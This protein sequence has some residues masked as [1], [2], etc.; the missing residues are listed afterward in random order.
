[1]DPGASSRFHGITADMLAAQ[2]DDGSP[3]DECMRALGD[4]WVVGWN[5]LQYDNGVMQEEGKRYGTIYQDGLI[6][7]ACCLDLGI[8]YKACK[9]WD[10]EKW[11]GASRMF[12]NETPL[13][14]QSRISEY[15]TFG[16]N[17]NLAQAVLSME[18]EVEGVTMHRALADCQMI[19]KVMLE[20][21]TT[22]RELTF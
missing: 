22:P 13:H 4:G 2:P 17:W 15:R 11:A 6:N 3:L 20:F 10:T 21:Q 16:I 14:Y 12:E 8:L 9:M 19:H 7:P 5:I 18:I 1:V